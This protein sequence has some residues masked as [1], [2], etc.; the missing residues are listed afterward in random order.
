MHY[1][2]NFCFQDMFLLPPTIFTG[3]GV[4]NILYLNLFLTECKLINRMIEFE[5]LQSGNHQSNNLGKKHQWMLKL[6]GKII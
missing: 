3:P 5:K 1:F 4:D 2:S 6:V